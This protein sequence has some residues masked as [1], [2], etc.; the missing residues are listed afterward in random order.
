[1]S[2]TLLLHSDILDKLMRVA[3]ILETVPE[4]LRI[5]VQILFAF[6]LITEFNVT[7]GNQKTQYLCLQY[8]IH[9]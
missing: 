9:L 6:M 3:C 7:T 1:M 4:K 8:L 2:V 5:Q